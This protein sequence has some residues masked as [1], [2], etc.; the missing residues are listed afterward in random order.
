MCKSPLGHKE[1]ASQPHGAW[2]S[3]AA[4]A[5]G[6]LT[7]SAATISTASS[8]NSAVTCEKESALPCQL[9][10]Q[11]SRA[12]LLAEVLRDCLGWFVGD[13]G[14]VD[15]ATSRNMASVI[16]TLRAA[17]T[18][19]LSATAPR[20]PTKVEPMRLTGSSGTSEPSTR[21]HISHHT[22]SSRQSSMRTPASPETRV[23]FGPDTQGP[24]ERVI[25][26]VICV[27]Q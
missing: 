23:E 12:L 6:L 18:V 11:R 3:V 17:R 26:F 4:G 7:N 21:G 1:T 16:L 14:A 2:A 13:V 9:D 20:G 19:R 8:C 27:N 15:V 24:Q 25:A 10:V 5:N 22:V